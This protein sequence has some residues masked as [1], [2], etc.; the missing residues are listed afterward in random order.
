MEMVKFRMYFDKDEETKWLNE[1]SDEGYAMTGFA[2]CFYKFEE[3]EKGKWRYQVDFSDNMF[4]VSNEYREFMNS[5]GVEIV[6]LW[7]FWVILRKLTSEGEFE[8]YTDVESRIE[9]YTKIRTMFKV[10][11]AIELI[12]F[13]IE[14]FAVAG[15]FGAGYV[16]LALLL[17]IIVALYNEINRIDDILDSLKER[18]TGIEVQRRKRK[19]SPFVPIGLLAVSLASLAG[20]SLPHYVSLGIKLVGIILEFIGLVITARKKA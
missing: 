19:V 10:A 7:G 1:M 2:F 17:P 20:D 13:F 5:V 15:G 3:C 4:S 8:L 12:C 11:M 16:F 9:N 14:F 18:K 6:T